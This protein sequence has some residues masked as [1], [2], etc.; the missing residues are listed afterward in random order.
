MNVLTPIQPN[1]STYRITVPATASTPLLI[2]PASNG[3]NTFASLLN[4]GTAFVVISI[5][6]TSSTTLTPTIPTTGTAFPPAGTW[7]TVSQAIILPP[8]MNYPI[9]IPAPSRPFYVSII[10]SAANGEFFIT[11]LNA[12]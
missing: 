3:T 12:G 7:G 11:P 2:T 1:G 8:S 9:I 4:T 10:G 5:G 6:L